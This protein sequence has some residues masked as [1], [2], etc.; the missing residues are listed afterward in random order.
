MEINLNIISILDSVGAIQGIIFGLILIILNK[1]KKNSCYCLG[2]FLILFSL[3]RLPYLLA[4]LNILE[5]YPNLLLLPTFALWVLSPVFFIY[6]QK[7]SIFSDQKLK[8]WLLLPGI[9]YYVFQVCVFI[10]PI[11]T[12]LIIV[13]QSWP[14]LLKIIGL[15]YSTIIAIWNI[16]YI[17][18]HNLEVNKQYATTDFKELIWA[19]NFLFFY[20]VGTLLYGIQLYVIPEIIF[21]KIYF[22]LFD[23]ILIYWLSFYGVV[24]LNVVSLFSNR[25]VMNTQFKN[26]STEN[27]QNTTDNTDLQELFQQINNYVNLSEVYK[28]TELTIMNVADK[29]GVHPRRISKVINIDRGQNFNSYINQFR[30]DK[31]I[32]LLKSP[33]VHKYSMEGIGAE[34]GFNSKSTF[35]AAFKKVTGTTPNKYKEQ[36]V[37]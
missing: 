32:E 21:S 11:Q 12:K 29:L 36:S 17:S 15:I 31:A 14:D 2:V 33:D 27:S 30:I 26:D 8:Y 7:I 19:N 28:E 10:L 16:K 34:V 9:I 23:M 24:Q 18:N 13:E 5:S 3:Q 4:E 1:W 22:L 20:I 6:T 37:A 35:Y 25:E